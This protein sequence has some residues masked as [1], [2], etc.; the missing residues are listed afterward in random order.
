MPCLEEKLNNHLQPWQE[1]L[2]AHSV[3]SCS[4]Q[5]LWTHILKRPTTQPEAT[6]GA[7]TVFYFHHTTLNPTLKGTGRKG[8]TRPH[9]S[10]E[11]NRRLPASPNASSLGEEIYQSLQP[12]HN[13]RGG[14]LQ[15]RRAPF[16]Q[17]ANSSQTCEGK[18]RQRVPPHSTPFPPF[19]PPAPASP[20]LCPFPLR[21]GAV[22]RP[23]PGPPGVAGSPDVSV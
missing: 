22:R 3:R 15:G 8:E 23:R 12:S 14:G 16:P 10:C 20:A 9:R 13:T 19:P 1:I 17:A 21:A 7:R 6:E 4:S 2:M 11:R 18:G 5:A